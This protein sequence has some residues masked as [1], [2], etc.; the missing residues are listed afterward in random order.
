[1]R[2]LVGF[3]FVL[4]VLASPWGAGAQDAE[5]LTPSSQP[6]MELELNDDGVEVAPPPPPTVDGYT[7]GEMELRVQRAKIGV[8][9]SAVPVFIGTV[10]MLAS[11]FSGG[12]LQPRT[13][14]EAETDR[15]TLIGGGV[16]AG[17]GALSMI[18]TG[19][20]LGVRKRKMRELQKAHYAPPRRAQWDPGTSR[21]S[22]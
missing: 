19:I 6:A 13:P 17:A 22:F 2:Y 21:I 5:E 8:G 16:V 14:E 15:R 11:S 18:A 9:I 12:L 1:M 4:L 7:L 3:V 20:L 10:L